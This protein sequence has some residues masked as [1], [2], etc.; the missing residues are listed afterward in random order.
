M[1]MCVCAKA[2]RRSTPCLLTLRRSDLLNEFKQR[3]LQLTKGCEAEPA[4]ALGCGQA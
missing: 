1:C 3:G 2:S 4:A